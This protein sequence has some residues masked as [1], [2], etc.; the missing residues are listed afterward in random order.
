VKFAA[1]VLLVG[2]LL[3]LA[4][5]SDISIEREQKKESEEKEK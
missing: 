3:F 4:G 5:R 2:A 1:I